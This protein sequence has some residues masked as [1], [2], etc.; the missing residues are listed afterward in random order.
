MGLALTIIAVAVALIAG[1]LVELALMV[2]VPSGGAVE[3]A[4]KVVAAPLAVCGVTEPQAEAPQLTDQS[5]PAMA[6]SFVT[7]AAIFPL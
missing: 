1:L 3:G 4:L 2:T 7:N 6:G 5:T